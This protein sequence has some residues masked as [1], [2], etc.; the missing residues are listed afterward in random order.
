M[1]A[2]IVGTSRNST[3][4]ASPFPYRAA[5]RRPLG[6]QSTSRGLADAGL[7][8]WVALLTGPII[9]GIN[10]LGGYLS[11]RYKGE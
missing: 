8:L 3:V 5:I 10:F 11:D 2:S 9:L 1:A 7:P 4:T 6:G